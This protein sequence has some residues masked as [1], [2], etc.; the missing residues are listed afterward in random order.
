LGGTGPL[1]SSHRRTPGA[2][3]W[4][5]VPRS[6]LAKLATPTNLFP[7]SLNVARSIGSQPGHSTSVDNWPAYV[8]RKVRD[9][10]LRVHNAPRRCAFT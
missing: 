4:V 9:E 3:N 8:D 1:G 6:H 5:V 10:S 7:A 2:D